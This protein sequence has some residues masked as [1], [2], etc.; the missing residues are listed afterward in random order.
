[1]KRRGILLLAALLAITLFAAGAEA[2]TFLSIATGGVAGVY[3]PLGGGLAQVLSKHVPDIEVTAESS[4]ASAA[5]INLIAAGEVTMALV[6]N[7]V[8]FRAV[9]GAAPFKAPVT[10]LRMIASLYPEHVHCV[11]TK[12][13][14]VK[15]I[16]GLK[17]KRVS[18]GAPGSGVADSVAA[19]LPVAGLKDTDM[20]VDFLDFANTAERIQD[21]QLDAG[22]VLAGYPTAA[23]MALAAQKDIDL[24]SYEDDLLDR[25][26]A[27]YPFF[28]KDVIPAGTYTGVDHDTPTPAVMAVLVCDSA[29]PDDLVYDI[30]KAIFENLDELKPVHDKAKLIALDKALEA[31]SINVHPG[32]AKYYTEKGFDIP[33]F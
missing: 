17:G 19:I 12:A 11:T 28:A 14:G 16:A 1:M 20:K 3:Y 2:K 9:Q 24:V 15:T 6:Q 10:N 4:N 32:A 8:A 5:N 30:T 29:L 27:E 31:A 13:S 23:I 18:V 7:D 33:T 26:T 25:L 21:G 22:F